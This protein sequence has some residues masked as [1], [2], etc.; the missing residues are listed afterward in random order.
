MNQKVFDYSGYYLILLGDFSLGRFD[1]VARILRDCWTRYMANTNILVLNEDQTD[2]ALYT[3]FPFAPTYC[4]IVRPV[5]IESHVH[6]NDMRM[7]WKGYFPDKARHMY[8]CPITVSPTVYPPYSILYNVNGSYDFG[9]IDGNVLKSLGHL[10]NFS[11]VIKPLPA[12]L[13]YTANNKLAVDMVMHI[14]NR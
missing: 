14:W 6:R 1:V 8:N 13:D 7:G 5:M 2:A 3:Y 4:E 9:G 10:M 12:D 11:I